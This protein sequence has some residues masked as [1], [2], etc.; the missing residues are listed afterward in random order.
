[1]GAFHGLGENDAGS[2][3]RATFQ[4]LGGAGNEQGGKQASE[5]CLKLTEERCG[6]FHGCREPV[7]DAMPTAYKHKTVSTHE[8]ALTAII[9][10]EHI[11]LRHCANSGIK[12]KQ[13]ACE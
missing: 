3:G 12:R 5:E 2:A 1:V 11:V 6:S 9:K 7:Y 4:L 8:P 13:R 10:Q